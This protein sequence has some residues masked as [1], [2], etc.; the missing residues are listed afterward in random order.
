MRRQEEQVQP[1]RQ[2]EIS[3]RVPARLIQN[4]EDVFVRPQPLFLGKSRQREGKGRGI[5]RWHEQPAGPSAP[6]LHKPIQIHPLIALAD[7][8]PHSAPLAGPDAAQDGFEADAVLILAPEFKAG[9]W[10]R[11]LQREDLLGQFF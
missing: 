6:G 2:L 5:D 10:V 3:T 4:Q 11:L 9:F 8:S 7:Y 1:C